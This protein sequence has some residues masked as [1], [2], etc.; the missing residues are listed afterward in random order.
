MELIASFLTRSRE[1]LLEHA[2][3]EGLCYC[4]EGA[5]AVLSPAWDRLRGRGGDFAVKRCAR[6]GTIRTI[7]RLS[8][9][10]LAPFYEANSPPADELE[11]GGRVGAFSC[12][13]TDTAPAPSSGGSKRREP[14]APNWLR[15]ICDA[16][17]SIVSPESRPIALTAPGRVLEVG[18]GHGELLDR[19]RAAGWE[20]WA[21]EEDARAAARV[22]RRGHRVI[23]GEFRAGVIRDVAFDMV[24]MSHV[25]EHVDDPLATCR[26]VRSLLKPDGHFLIRVPN[27]RGLLPK[28]FALQDWYNLD[29]PRHLWHFSPSTL[30]QLLHTAGFV[31]VREK[32]YSTWVDYAATIRNMWHRLMRGAGPSESPPVS[33]F[34][35]VLM[36][37]MWIVLWRPLDSF[38][39]GDRIFVVAM[40]GTYTDGSEVEQG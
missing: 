17:A 5:G 18:C 31:V 33:R 39:L 28:I 30:S 19:L 25:L 11:V 27:I 4:Q 21:I 26:T 7:P 23:A 1:P 40:P 38:G 22:A 6:C 8:R 15:N 36:K 10:D 20:T 34:T 29:V 32:R 35:S 12:A 3:R 16:A 24:W 37:L 9:L 13:E 2:G 14:N